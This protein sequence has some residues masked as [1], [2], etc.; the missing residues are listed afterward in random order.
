[1]I[2]IVGILCLIAIVSASY[3]PVDERLCGLTKDAKRL[4][5]LLQTYDYLL[6]PQLPRVDPDVVFYGVPF[7][8]YGL[9][10]FDGGNGGNGGTGGVDGDGGNGG[11]GGNAINNGQGGSGGNGGNG[12]GAYGDGIGDG[13]EGGNGGEGGVLG[14]QGGSGGSG[15]DG[16]ENGGEGGQGG[17]GGNGGHLGGNGGSGGSGGQGGFFGGNG[18]D[19]GAGGNGGTG[20]PLVPP[21]IAA[22]PS[23]Y[24]PG[25]LP[26]NVDLCPVI[27]R[28]IQRKTAYNTGGQ[29]VYLVQAK[30]GKIKIQQYFD[31]SRCSKQRCALLGARAGN[32]IQKFEWRKALVV[33]GCNHGEPD[34]KVQY[35]AIPSCCACEFLH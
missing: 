26:R 15:G 11:N 31:E 6:N 12:G 14:G 21:F 29:L 4:S 18:G 30:L 2:K 33:A 16:G 24:I 34:V 5:E 19:G 13:G 3:D 8:N 23:S 35:V 17:T 32:C 25:L 9:P 28:N 7:I 22:N 10:N 27:R 20:Y 1:M